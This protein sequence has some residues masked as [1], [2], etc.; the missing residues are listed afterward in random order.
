MGKI[1]RQKPIKNKRNSE[2]EGN[3]HEELLSDSKDNAIQTMLDQ[4]QA[5]N[6]E[7]KY[8]ALQTL[9]LLVE[10][11]G[12]AE[13]IISKGVVKSAAPLLID[14]V[15]SVRNAAASALHTL[16][17]VNFEVCDSLMEQDIMTPLIFYFNE[18]AAKLIPEN[19]LKTKD[20]DIDTFIQ[21]INLLMN[22]CESSELAIKYADQSNIFDILPRFLEISTFGS[23]VVIATLQCLFVIVEDNPHGIQKVKTNFETQ[24]QQLIVLEGN[25]PTAI[26][27]KT[28]AAGIIINTFSGNIC[29]LPGTIISQVLLILA[30]AL[31]VDHRLVCNQLSSSVPLNNA[32]GKVN[33]PKGKEAKELEKQIQT[34]SYI[35]DAQQSAI[36]IIAN[37]CS[38]DSG[39]YF[40]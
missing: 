10:T 40:L 11:P 4:L 20:E 15:N 13:K 28:L 19:S 35:L 25:E 24:L 6:I 23:N 36:E 7:E 8:C 34:V 39:K 1:R 5:A 17:S 18:Y 16:S 32:S 3:A 27:I 31:S 21:S 22:L 33:A 9:S 38:Y 12:N 14:P 26:L 30:N 37:I 29:S 2:N